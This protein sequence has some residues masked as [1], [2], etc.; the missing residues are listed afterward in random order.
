[1]FTIQSH[2]LAYNQKLCNAVE[3][4]L[5]KLKAKSK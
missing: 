4:G 3:R 1:M 2:I 5:T